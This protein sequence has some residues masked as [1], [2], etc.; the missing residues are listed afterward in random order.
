MH[1]SYFAQDYTGNTFSAA[2]ISQADFKNEVRNLVV[3]GYRV[4]VL[5]TPERFNPDHLP[6]LPAHPN[7]Q[8]F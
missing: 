2:N 5:E 4:W 1:Y 7:A 8:Q 6:H 3:G